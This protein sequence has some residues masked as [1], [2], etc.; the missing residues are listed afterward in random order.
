MKRMIS[1]NQEGAAEPYIDLNSNI[2]YN[3][4]NNNQ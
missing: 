1:L 3:P 2:I 4:Y